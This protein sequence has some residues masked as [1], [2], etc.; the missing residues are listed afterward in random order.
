MKTFQQNK[1]Q[2]NGTIKPKL[3]RDIN[4]RKI[5]GVCSGIANYFNLDIS[6]VRIT[7]FLL[8]F[9]GIFSAGISTFMV[10]FVYLLLWLI[11]PKNSMTYYI[12]S[13]EH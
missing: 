7:W 9:F 10:V 12:E 6:L 13:K 3:L 1:N 4:N 11:L 8:A 2:N 5:A